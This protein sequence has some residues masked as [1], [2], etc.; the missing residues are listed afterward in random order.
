[1]SYF[2]PYI[3]ETGYHY[4]TYNDIIEQLVDD[5]QTIYGSGIYLG[6]DSQDYEMLSKIAE[7]IYD[8][9]QAV[10]LAYNSHSPV[11]AIGTGLDC[12]VAINGIARK[13]ATKSIVTLTLTGTAGTIIENG[14]VADANGIMWELPE[15]VQIGAGGTVDAQ[16]TCRDYGTVAAAANSVNKIM[17]PVYGWESVTNAAQAT[18]GTIV[19]TDS[20]LRARQAVSVALPSKSILEGLRAALKAL[21]EIGR[22]ELYENTG[23]TT[24]ANGIPGHSICAVIEGADDQD[25][26]ETIIRRKSPGCGTYGSTSVSVS[27]ESGQTQAICFQRLKYV[28]VDI[29]IT[30]TKRAGWTDS[31]EAAIKSAVVEYLDSFDIGT[32]LTTSII[33]MVAQTVNTDIRSPKFSVSLVKAARHEDTL[34]TEDVEIDFDETARGRE[35]YITIVAQS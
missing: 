16:A 11:T 4:P 30:L 29:E 6:N 26:A 5:M 1:M 35:T 24:D 23:S 32:D 13:Q 19:E 34:G 33:W 31:I 17:T 9:Y 2:K 18:I 28:D 7:K 3:D 21:P 12:V 10:E 27:D 14:L 8:T 20:E 22:C 25:I 15:T